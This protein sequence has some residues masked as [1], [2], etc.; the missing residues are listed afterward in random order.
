MFINF[1]KVLCTST[2][3]EKAVSPLYDAITLLGPYAMG[4]V[5]LLGIIYGIILGVKFAKSEK[6]DERAALQKA[7]ISGVI[8]FLAILVLIVI[9]YAIREPL[10]KFMDS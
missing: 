2:G 3:G 9:L 5:C 8:G 7:L 4:V 6:A 1:L 10:V